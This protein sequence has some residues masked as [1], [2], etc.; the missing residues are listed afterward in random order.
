VVVVV[1]DALRADRLGC[2][3]SR[4]GL[5]PFLDEWA[6]R[7]WV[8]HRAHSAASYTIPSVAS[9]L[10]AR[11]LS[12]HGVEWFDSVLPAEETTLTEVLRRHGYVTG[13]FTASPFFKGFEQGFDVA[14]LVEPAADGPPRAHQIGAAARNFLA[15]H[16]SLGP[17][18][19]YLHLIESH[20]PYDLPPPDRRPPY[21]RSAPPHPERVMALYLAGHQLALG[22][23]ALAE[24]EDAYDGAIVVLDDRLRA[25]FA[26]LRTQGVLE[27]AIVVITAD[28]GEDFGEHGTIGHARTLYETSTWVPLLVRVPGQTQR[29]DV[30]EVVSLVD[31][32][33]TVLE[34]LDIAAP[35]TFTGRA[36]IPGPSAGSWR[37]SALWRSV[38]RRWRDERDRAVSEFLTPSRLPLPPRHSAAVVLGSRKLVVG[39]DGSR[40]Y[41]D[42][43]RDPAERTSDAVG[44]ADRARLDETLTR[45]RSRTAGRAPS[46]AKAPL[47]AQA[48]ERLRALG[49]VTD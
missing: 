8:F 49:Y 36:L 13:S 43:A 2:L 47:D 23:D 45:V 42:L 46:A 40:E 22:A 41:Y 44:P 39:A 29:V 37:P 4:R 16:G 11:L 30:E 38:R 10:T 33:P 31:V 9:L 25:L 48:R 24:L 17:V 1:L 26:E 21:R 27:H 12:E 7:S 18:F 28:H 32:A 19:L 5:T 14:K 3:G 20:V 15:T 35:P 6:E 34:L